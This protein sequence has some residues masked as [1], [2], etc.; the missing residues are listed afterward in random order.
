MAE[1]R[2]IFFD[3][4]G[5]LLTNGLDE[6]Q[7]AHVLPQFGLDIAEY[8]KRHHEANEAWERGL[9]TAQEY[10]DKTVFYEPRSFSYDALWAAVTAES[11]VLHQE[12]FE[13][14]AA[15]AGTGRY[16]MSTLNNESRE[17]NDY[18]IEAFGLKKIFTTFICSGYVNEM[19]PHAGIYRSALEI[20]QAKPAES[21]FIDD[22]ENNVQPARALGMHG[23]TFTSPA[24]LRAELEKLG[25]ALV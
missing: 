13:I 7:R 10:F 15:I 18:R 24:Q 2:N 16:R 19:K 9:S 1:I 23:I 20:T 14:A 6:S 8:N 17:L 4:G 5:V 21:V 12:C 3:I 11:H 22:R 25:V